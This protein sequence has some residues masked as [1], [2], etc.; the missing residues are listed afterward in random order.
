MQVRSQPDRAAV[1]TQ[2]PFGKNRP[3]ARR[4]TRQIFY[5]AESGCFEH[6]TLAETEK[7]MSEQPDEAFVTYSKR[8][9]MVPAKPASSRNSPQFIPR[10]VS[11]DPQRKSFID[12]TMARLGVFSGVYACRSRFLDLPD[13]PGVPIAPRALKRPKRK[14]VE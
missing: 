11:D 12:A 1:R 6:Q 2:S 10:S 4:R 7:R 9:S 5:E 3:P 8:G 14:F 13:L